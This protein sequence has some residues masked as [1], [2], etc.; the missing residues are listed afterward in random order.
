MKHK[1]IN[2]EKAFKDKYSLS[3]IYSLMAYLQSGIFWENRKEST[4][5]SKICNLY[6][7]GRMDSNW[8]SQYKNHSLGIMIFLHIRLHTSFIKL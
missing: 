3:A 2:V 6:L 4:I 8:A 5:A 7:L 1:K